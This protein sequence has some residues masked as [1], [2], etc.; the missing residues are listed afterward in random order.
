M[1]T[2][3]HIYVHHD[4]LCIHI[5]L[6]SLRRLQKE[7][8][9]GLAPSKFC[10]MRKIRSQRFSLSNFTF[11]F[12]SSLEI[13]HGVLDYM[14]TDQTS[15]VQILSGIHV[16][17]YASAHTRHKRI[18]TVK[19]AH[20]RMQVLQFIYMTYKNVQMIYTYTSTH[21]RAHARTHAHMHSHT[22]TNVHT[23]A[24][25]CCNSFI[26]HTR[27]CK[28]YIRTQARTHVHTRAHMHTCTHALTHTHK[29]TRTH[30]HTHKNTLA[31]THINTYI[32]TYVLC[33]Y[34]LCV[35]VRGY[36]CVYLFVLV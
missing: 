27:T 9:I 8:V 2:H 6:P 13:G 34:E 23:H 21:T 7:S 19:R 22:H 14:P 26:W 12:F 3:I 17:M 33:T 20:T 25:R 36:M 15:W 18:N 16:H 31:H 24:C 32:H 4:G 11:L 29:R 10:K 1:Y 35:C 5:S 28:W 30:T